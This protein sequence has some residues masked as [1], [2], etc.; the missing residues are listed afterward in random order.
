[1]LTAIRAEM[2]AKNYWKVLKIWNFSSQIFLLYCKWHQI[3]NFCRHKTTW[4]SHCMQALLQTNEG[5][6]RGSCLNTKNLHQVTDSTSQP[7]SAVSGKGGWG[8]TYIW[9]NTHLPPKARCTHADIIYRTFM[10]K[11]NTNSHGSRHKYNRH[12]KI[13]YIQCTAHHQ[14]C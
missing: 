1:M 7:L 10:Q 13:L 14:C 9:L 2:C 5:G 8:E 4:V 12:S 3:L 6:W 11:K